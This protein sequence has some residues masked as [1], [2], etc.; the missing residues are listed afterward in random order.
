MTSPVRN[1]ASPVAALLLLAGATGLHAQTA[2][3]PTWVHPW[4]FGQDPLPG[5]YAPPSQDNHVVVDPVTGLIHCTISDETGLF[6]LWGELLYTFD[7]SGTELTT[8]PPPVVGN[9][10]EAYFEGSMFNGNATFKLDAYGGN[11]IA[12]NA[13]SL[14]HVGDWASYASFGVISG[15]HGTASLQLP[16]LGPVPFQVALSDEGHVL[17]SATGLVG[18]NP[19]GW[20]T[21]QV[22]TGAW[23]QDVHVKDGTVWALLDNGQLKRIDMATGATLP[24]AATTIAGQYLLVGPDHF[25]VVKGNFNGTADIAA[26]DGQG[27]AVY[28]T[29]VVFGSYGAVT[30]AVLDNTGRVWITYTEMDGGGG[31]RSPESWRESGRTAQGLALGLMAQA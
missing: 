8:T 25:S 7:P 15:V 31:R 13:F 17:S 5:L 28:T 2:L 9:V 11:F 26:F 3:T 4:S 10:P 1:I 22:T 12:A 23:V 27:N 24:D 29:N 16:S 30:G 20:P 18:L 21:W 19:D 6:S 14:T